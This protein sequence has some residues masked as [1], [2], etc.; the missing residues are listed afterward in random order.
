[1]S[2]LLKIL[3][4]G[5]GLWGLTLVICFIKHLWIL[6]VILI[7]IGVYIAINFALYKELKNNV[8]Q[9]NATGTIRNVDFLII[10]EYIDVHA[11]VDD[12]SSVFAIL[13][14]GKSLQASKEILRHTFSI[15][16]DGGTVI[17]TN[18]RGIMKGYSCFDTMWLHDITIKRLGLKKVLC[19]FPL[20]VAPIKS[21][22]LMMKPDKEKITINE[23]LC[24][25]S[26]IPEF[27]SKRGLIFK[28]YQIERSK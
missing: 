22:R 14:P 8:N 7:L 23:T 20:F 28:Y 18:E 11:L 25:D 3:I 10:G 26:E 21:L 6:L 24:P 15:L 1:M 13:S 9:M 5:G 27:C 16:R 12:S 17:V 4:L 19:R 2:R